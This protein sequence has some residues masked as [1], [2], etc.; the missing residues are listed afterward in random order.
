MAIK[1]DAMGSYEEGAPVPVVDISKLP[2]RGSPPADVLPAEPSRAGKKPT[3]PVLEGTV[4]P[5]PEAALAQPEQ[6]LTDLE[7][8]RQQPPVDL[9]VLR[10]RIRHN[11]EDGVV[12]PTDPSQQL[13]ADSEGNIMLGDERNPATAHRQSEIPQSIFYA[14]DLNKIAQA[15]RDNQRRGDV[16]PADPSRQMFTNQEGDILMGDQVDPGNAQRYSRITQET[17][18]AG[19]GPRLA[20]ERRI[21]SDKMPGNTFQASD[22]TTTGWVYSVT[23]EFSDTYTLFAWYDIGTATYK[24]SLVEPDLRGRVGVEDCHLFSD[25]T[26]CLKREGGPGYRNLEDAYSRSVLWTR[27]ASCYRRGYGFQFNLGQEG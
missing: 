7:W 21:V 9:N 11:L 4:V 3:I 13:F 5:R 24:I 14:P 6:S 17:F 8:M 18:Y 2:G 10:D 25:G 26:I 23:N 15:A 20:L 12:S 16:D 1:E 22:G 27:G 19:E